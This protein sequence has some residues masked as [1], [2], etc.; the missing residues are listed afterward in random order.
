VRRSGKLLIVA[1]NVCH[2]ASAS[3]RSADTDLMPHSEF[4]RRA[5]DQEVQPFDSFA[6]SLIRLG[7]GEAIAY[8][9][10]QR[11]GMACV[12]NPSSFRQVRVSRIDYTL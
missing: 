6:Q 3:R 9:P 2:N 4:A 1:T 11:A 10:F 12:S 8:E 5:Y 7:F